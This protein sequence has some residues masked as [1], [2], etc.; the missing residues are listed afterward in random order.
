M[1]LKI[2][3]IQEELGLLK[4][5]GLFFGCGQGKVALQKRLEALGDAAARR[6]GGVA[7]EP[8]ENRPRIVGGKE[9]AARPGDV[10]R[11]RRKVLARFKDGLCD[12]KI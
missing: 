8:K 2:V 6:N 10:D 12:L 9:G 11:H 7:E 4:I 5:K 1:L 3:F